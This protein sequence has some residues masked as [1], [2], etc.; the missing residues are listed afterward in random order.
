MEATRCKVL[1]RDACGDKIVARR[2]MAELNRDGRDEQDE[3][4]GLKI[5]WIVCIHVYLTIA[6]ARDACGDK[7]RGWVW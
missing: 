2:L 6:K 4:C 5:L 1:P 3:P 7:D